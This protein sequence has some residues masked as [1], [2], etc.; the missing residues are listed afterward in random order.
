MKHF[1]KS[2]VEKVRTS[3]NACGVDSFQEKLQVG[4]WHIGRCSVCSLIYVNPVSLFKKTSY[5]DLS[6]DYYYTRLQREIT[7]AKVEFEKGQLR[8]QLEEVLKLTPHFS[9]VVKFLDLG[10]GP[11]LAVHA[12]VEL[13][14]EAIGIDIDSELIRLGKNILNVDI[15]CDNIIESRFD[16]GQFNFVRIKSVLHLLPNPYDVLVEA[17]RVLAPGGVVLI[18]VPNEAGLLNQLN[19]LLGRKRKGRLGTLVLPYHSHAFTPATLKRLLVRSGLKIHL[20]KTT[21]PR[22]PA[23]A[24]IDQLEKASFGGELL[25]IVWRFS[26]A[27]HRGSLLVAYASK[28]MCG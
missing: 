17:K 28:Q 21:T 18:T 12:A 22:D 24:S 3:C 23:Y 25:A 20:V 13:G 8:S 9:P 6:R 26:K 16:D 14:W 7:P 19:L 1:D 15:R 5:Y 10:C 2:Y 4:E 27:I 11:G